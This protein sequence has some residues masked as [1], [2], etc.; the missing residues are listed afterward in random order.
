MP[1]IC[2]LI[3]LFFGGGGDLSIGGFVFS[4]W[5]NAGIRLPLLVVVMF[6]KLFQIIATG[7]YRFLDFLVMNL[8]CV[9]LL[10]RTV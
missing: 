5:G 9:L 7:Q 1:S 10:C 2:L 4:L 3:L 6:R 8:L